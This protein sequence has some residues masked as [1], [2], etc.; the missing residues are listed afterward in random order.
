LIFEKKEQSS[1]AKQKMSVM[2]VNMNVGMA[3]VPDADAV[4]VEF[5]NPQDYIETATGNKMSKSSLLCGPK[6]IRFSGKVTFASLS[7]VHA[8]LKLCAEHCEDGKH[9]AWRLS[10]HHSRQV[11]GHL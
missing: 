7:L 8:V 5:Y 11:L 6:H 4:P 9:R 2:S 10:E 3:I 1:R